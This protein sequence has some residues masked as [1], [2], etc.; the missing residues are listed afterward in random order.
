MPRSQRLL[1]LLIA[2]L[3]LAYIAI[4]VLQYRQ[5]RALDEVMR[6]G[7]INALWTFAQLNVEYERLDHA[8]NA[9][10][11]DANAVTHAQ[12]Q[13]RYDLFMSRIGAVDSGTPQA[14]MQADASYQQGMRDL[15]AFT[16]AGDQVLGPDAASG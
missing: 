7:D 15:R 4:G 3:V 2:S 9:H 14:L 13:L 1:R 10:L 12:L 5:Y 8:L 11:L 16:A 6:R